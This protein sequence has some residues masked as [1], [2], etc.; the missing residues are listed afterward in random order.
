MPTTSTPSRPRLGADEESITEWLTIH[1]REATWTAVIVVIVVLGAWYYQKSRSLRAERAE[2]QYFQARQ[3]AAAGNLPV[4]ISDL[5]RVT[6][7]YDG[8]R[9][10]TQ[11]ALTLAQT[12][13][14]QKKYKE[15]IDAL[16][17]AEAKAADDFKPSVHVLEAAGYEELKDFA[18]AAAQYEAA[19][20]ASTF[21]ADKAQYRASAARDYMAAGK[22]DKARA[23]WEDLA[24][25]DTGPVSA[26]AKVRLGEVI[27]KPM[28]T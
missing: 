7:R 1:R 5:Q 12:F 20:A 6:Q 15:G 27:A 25:D 13:Y 18:G 8:T 19:A 2:T 22:N 14:D 3:A 26:E 9:A 24:K 16:E 11:A 4:A 21:P 23:I 10:G 17:K 28:T